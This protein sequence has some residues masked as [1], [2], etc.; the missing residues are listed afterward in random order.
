MDFVGTVHRTDVARHTEELA[1]F[2]VTPHLAGSDEPTG[3]I[4]LLVEGESR[5]M[6]TARG[7]NALT[8]P[9]RAE[10]LLRGA[11]HLHLTGYSLFDDPS[12]W[13]PLLASAAQLGLT[14][15]IDPSSSAFLADSGIDAFLTATAGADVIF[16][17][18]DEG[19]L[20][21]GRT[22]PAEVAEALGELY[23]IVAVT[24]GPDGAELRTRHGFSGRVPAAL[25]QG[26]LVDP[27][28]AGDAFAAGFL[29]AW[30]G[31]AEPHAA[32]I[33]GAAVAARAV[34]AVGA[35]PAPPS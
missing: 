5:T 32:G 7:A 23:P 8:G 9:D 14:V 11:G 13:S 3:S 30:L 29:A 26:G 35:R 24:L 33:A 15:S 22:D 2:G 16:P 20:L 28:G 25:P 19:R 31:G 17:N 18:L 4:V 27:T 12:A 1:S 34:A 6:F 10:G 21:S